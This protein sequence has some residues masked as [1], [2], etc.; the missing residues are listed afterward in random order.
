MRKKLVFT[1]DDIQNWFTNFTDNAKIETM[2]WL[3]E[4][5]NE[6]TLNQIGE[7]YQT[8]LDSNHDGKLNADDDSWRDLRVWVDQN[9]DALTNRGE[10]FSLDK[11]GIKSLN[12]NYVEMMD[13][14]MYGNQTRERSTYVRRVNG[15]ERPLQMI[16]VWF[17]T[18]VEN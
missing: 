8:D 18:L 12:L 1:V 9:A 13:V 11:L 6:C 14:D 17:N 10:L 15:R 7:N 16:D 4:E 5:I 3:F 2:I